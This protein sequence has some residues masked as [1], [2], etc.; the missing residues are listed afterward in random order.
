MKFNYK[1]VATVLGSAL[2]LGS[3]VALAAAAS[4]TPS[5]F[6]DG[7]IALVVGQKAALSDMKAA[8][9]L[10]ANLAPATSTTTASSTTVSG[11][12]SYK[13]EKSSQ[14]FWLGTNVSAIRSTLDDTQLPALLATG[15]YIDSD[16]D[17]F[18]YKQSVA[19]SSNLKLEMFN[20][21]NYKSDTPTLG[22]FLSGD[23][24]VLSYTLDM[25]DKPYF[26]KLETTNLPIMGKEYYV[27]DV[28]S[29][30]KTITLLDAANDV[31]VTEGEAST[32][33]VGDKT[34]ELSTWIGQ[35]GSDN[36]AKITVNG[37]TT[38]SLEAGQ[39]QR[40]S[41]GAYIG[42]K[43]IMYS[44]KDS[45]VSKVELS[46]G[47][48]KLKI[49]NA[50]KVELNDETVKNVI[51]TIGGTTQLESITL[52]W[53]INDKTFITKDTELVM[54]GF[55][56][57]KVSFGGV[58]FP[59]EESLTVESD[60]DNNMQLSGV[61]L[62][63]GA[64]DVPFLGKADGNVN[65]TY[66]GADTDQLIVTSSAA[67]ITYNGTSSSNDDFLIASWTDG[68][69]AESYLVRPVDFN[70]PTS[71]DDTVD[72][73]IN[74][75][76][77][78]SSTG[79]K[80]LSLSDELSLGNMDLSI[81]ALNSTTGYQSVTLSRGSDTG[82][83][84]NVL[85]TKEGMKVT[86]P[87][88]NDVNASTNTSSYV[89]KFQ[90]EN[91]DGDIGAGNTFNVTLGITASPD[92]LAE[93]SSVAGSNSSREKSA[94]DVYESWTYSA[95]AT[96]LVEDN[97]G[98]QGM[99]TITYHGGESFGDVYVNAPSATIAAGS[100]GSTT[101]SGVMTVYDNEVSSVSGKNLIVIG[102]SAVNSVASELLGGAGAGDS[103]TTATGVKAGEAIIKSFA[104]SGKVALLVAGFNAEDTSKAV[105]YLSNNAINTTVGGAGMKVTSA[106]TATAIT[107]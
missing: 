40:L 3:T 49:V 66:I 42:I 81:T 69:D 57:I 82:V 38:N 100:T 64:V 25:T 23:E 75:G 96:K 47:S 22:F 39:T 24:E 91:N 73:E 2:M 61:Q 7:G 95:L 101:T 59:T 45:A 54:P 26:N 79:Y 10:T 17:E 44:S 8:I 56:A 107:A 72:F 92:Y 43:D 32:L 28:A 63:N 103:F 84:F 80:D 12:D 27:L 5:S 11:G 67:T 97:S 16:N 77:G 50:S 31:V 94:T 29:N 104:R 53:T 102:G 6:T 55:G 85:Y 87:T 74:D 1:K 71:G 106:T 60:G 14:K 93:V 70:D 105:T 18:D 99:V 4:F 86:L 62:E 48:G 41:D 34:Y 68:T 51:G 9:D 13:I 30:N 78:W 90:E 37:E 65:F 52:Q 83:A 76:S 21:R 15:K 35:S 20:D 98:D 46:I 33:T 36:V 89:L 58:N 88:R 19:L